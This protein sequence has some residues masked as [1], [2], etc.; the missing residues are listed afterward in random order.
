MEAAERRATSGEPRLPPARLAGPENRAR[1]PP[2]GE[3]QR[4]QSLI[5]Q[6]RPSR[7]SRERI[8]TNCLLY[9]NV[10]ELQHMIK[11]SAKERLHLER[12]VAQLHQRAPPKKEGTPVDRPK[13][14]ILLF[15]LTP[16]PRKLGRW[17]VAPSPRTRN[18]RRR[19]LAERVFF[20]CR[21]AAPGGEAELASRLGQQEHGGFSARLVGCVRTKAL[22]AA[23]DFSR[24]G[25]HRLEKA[26]T[27]EGEEARGI[28]WVMTVFWAVLEVW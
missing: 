26:T 21:T 6:R 15:R 17:D 23:T 25:K 27:K 5:P 18:P 3:M 22:R 2:P 20:L 28:E 7:I 1:A 9:Q 24:V 4:R 19:P 16:F 11:Q 12:Q 10:G 8:V 14:A 13:S